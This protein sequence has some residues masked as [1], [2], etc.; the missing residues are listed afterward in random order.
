M[1]GEGGMR[2]KGGLEDWSIFFAVVIG[3]CKLA[4]D[5][6]FRDKIVKD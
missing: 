1:F 2:P 6:E 4:W 5:S 3:L